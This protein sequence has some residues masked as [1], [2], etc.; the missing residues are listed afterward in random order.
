MGLSIYYTLQMAIIL[1]SIEKF[2]IK[3]VSITVFCKNTM[4]MKTKIS[5]P[6][7]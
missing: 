7:R 5:L 1:A 4:C 3:P 2:L 6:D